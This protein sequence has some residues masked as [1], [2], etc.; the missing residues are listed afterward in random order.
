MRV[1]LAHDVVVDFLLQPPW[2]VSLAIEGRMPH[3]KAELVVY[4]AESCQKFFMRR[5]DLS[6]ASA[7]GPLGDGEHVMR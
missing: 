7:D 4:F 6:L 2:W 1:Q 5:H 3:L